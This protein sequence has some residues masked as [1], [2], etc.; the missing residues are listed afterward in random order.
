MAADPDAVKFTLTWQGGYLTTT[1]GLLKA[2][3]G[4]DFAQKVG[5]GAAKQIS[6]KGHTRTRIIG[7]T[8]KPI[9][10]YS[11]SV[12]GY[13]HRRKGQAAGGQP[14]LIDWEDSKWTARLGGS[15][16]DFKGWLAGVGKPTKPFTF[17]TE[18]GGLYS[19]AS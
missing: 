14:I 11:Y 16:Q 5:A 13:P 12:I 7:G 3:Y 10:G 15:I 4:A 9:S 19:S 18:R 1:M 17:T 6:V 2:I 8:A